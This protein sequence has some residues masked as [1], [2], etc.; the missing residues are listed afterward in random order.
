MEEKAARDRV[1]A[2]IEEDRR[3]RMAEDEARRRAAAGQSGEPQQ[4]V[5]V[6]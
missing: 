1:R 4:Q 6:R 5:G 2:Q 3:N